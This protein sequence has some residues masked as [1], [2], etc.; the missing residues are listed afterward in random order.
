MEEYIPKGPVTVEKIEHITEKSLIEILKEVP[1][2]NNVIDENPVFNP[3]EYY[4]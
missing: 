2:A 3:H 4:F 1:Y